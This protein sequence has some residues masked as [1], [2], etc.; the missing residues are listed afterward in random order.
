[1]TLEKD[2]L[3]LFSLKIVIALHISYKVLALVTHNF[4]ILVKNTQ[5]LAIFCFLCG[6]LPI[7]TGMP[8]DVS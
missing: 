2:F 7:I 5:L 4:H 8:F 6:F 1:M 3:E